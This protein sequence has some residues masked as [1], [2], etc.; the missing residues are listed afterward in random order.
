MEKT[1]SCLIEYDDEIWQ[2]NNDWKHIDLN[3]WFDYY[4]DNSY[5]VNMYESIFFTK[6]VNS[7]QEFV[8]WL[9]IDIISFN[10]SLTFY[11]FNLLKILPTWTQL[12]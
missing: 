5:H 12:I 10:K 1:T 8:I 3:V 4:T 7:W 6:N 9:I 2:M 11:F